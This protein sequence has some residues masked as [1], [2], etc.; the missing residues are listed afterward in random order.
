MSVYCIESSA[1]VAATGMIWHQWENCTSSSFL[2]LQSL[3][4]NPPLSLCLHLLIN[5]ELVFFYIPINDMLI[6]LGLEMSIERN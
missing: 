6:P 1:T 4:P 5:F 2:P 3:H